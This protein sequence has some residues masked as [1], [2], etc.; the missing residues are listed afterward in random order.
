[1]LICLGIDDV[2]HLL[3]FHLVWVMHI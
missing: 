3:W 1:M 2:E